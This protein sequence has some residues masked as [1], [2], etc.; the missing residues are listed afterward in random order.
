MALKAKMK[1]DIFD[2]EDEENEED[3][4]K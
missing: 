3:H 1:M 4:F 2:E